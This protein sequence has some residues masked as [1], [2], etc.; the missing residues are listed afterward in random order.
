MKKTPILLLIL[1]IILAQIVY[2]A[3]QTISVVEEPKPE[4]KK[5]NWVP[6]IIISLLVI[7]VLGLLLWLLIWLIKKLKEGADIWYKIRKDKKHLCKMHKDQWRV[8]A[9]FKF[10]KNNPIRIYFTNSNQIHSKIVGYYKGH[11][12][13]RDGNITILFNCRRKWLIFPMSDLLVINA[14]KEMIIAKKS[15]VINK[16][17]QEIITEHETVN[18]PQN[19]LTFNPD[20]VVLNAYSIDMDYRTEI[21]FPVIKD[22][23][24]NI[25]NMALPTY[26]SMKQVAIEGYLYDQTDDFV[27]VAKKSIDLNPMIRGVNKVS[28]SSSSI[29][30]QP[31]NMQR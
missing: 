15:V 31:Q 18:L 19:I 12:T 10:S 6:V 23:D 29:E 11:Y 25:I 22:I 30:T 24:G 2:S 1:I 21:F 7:L 28:D 20:E 26:E 9:F 4:A 3:T 8:K 17:K 13:S 27:K 5:F 16:G 14:K